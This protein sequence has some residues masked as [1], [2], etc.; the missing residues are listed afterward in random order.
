MIE[1]PSS[2]RIYGLSGRSGG[3]LW[4][5]LHARSET[6]WPKDEYLPRG[7]VFRCVGV[8]WDFGAI[9][10]TQQFGL[11]LMQAREQTIEQDV[12]GFSGEDAT[13]S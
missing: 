8:D 4:H 7:V 13:G 3:R 12:A 10:D 9:E 1:T 11:P 6:P 2:L 5:W